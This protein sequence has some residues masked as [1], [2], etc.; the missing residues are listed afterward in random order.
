[1]AA[2]S[3]A[4]P[5]ASSRRGSDGPNSVLRT[6]SER[7]CDVRIA[8]WNVNSLKARMERV[9]AWIADVGP[10]VLCLQE[11]KMSDE[12]FPRER[13]AE[14][15]FESA[16]HG[17]GR[18]NGVAILSRVGLDDPVAGFGDDR[19]ADP[20]AR[21]VW[22]TCAGVRIASAYVP[23]GRSLEDDH[24]RYKLDWL[25]RLRDVLE[26]T[27]TPDEPLMI[28]GDWNIAPEDRDVWDPA[29]F[30]DM[31]HTSAPERDALVAIERWGLID[32][33]RRFHSEPGL[34]SWWDY[35]GGSFH[36]RRGMRI[37]LIETTATVADRVRYAVID[38]DARKGDKPSDHAPVLVDLADD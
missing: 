29:Q 18:W 22:A 33:F 36:R 19:P 1:M 9:E 37:D 5:A 6:P 27:H 32:V 23:N 8:T 16:H 34:Y 2:G 13:F 21:L 26:S 7:L 30:V 10:D 15:G 35:R 31:T 11:T 24:Y 4:D 38:R 17:Q 12:A 3:T 28:L 14:L 20:D 25:A